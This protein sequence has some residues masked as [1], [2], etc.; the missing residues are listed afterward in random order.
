MG[1]FEAWSCL[2]RQVHTGQGFRAL[3]R[4]LRV[5]D[6]HLAGASAVEVDYTG[7]QPN[8]TNETSHARFTVAGPSRT[9]LVRLLGVGRNQP[10]PR[11]LGLGSETDRGET[12][13]CLQG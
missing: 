1:P 4:A 13:G 11:V 2:R 7:R 10:T 6:P 9:P 8:S 3:L 12:V 5:S